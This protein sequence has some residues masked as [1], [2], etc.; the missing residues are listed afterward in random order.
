[1]E[2]SR[3]GSL[4]VRAASRRLLD[5]SEGC[6]PTRKY[7]LKEH[8]V[9]QEL[10]REEAIS[11]GKEMINFHAA[12]AMPI[13]NK[14]LQSGN[15]FYA[16]IDWRLFEAARFE[17]ARTYFRLGHMLQPWDDSWKEQLKQ[18]EDNYEDKLNR[19]PGTDLS[20]R[21]LLDLITKYEQ[22]KKARKK[23]ENCN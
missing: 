2:S 15:E 3:W 6:P 18:L 9:I 12:S 13:I 22:L 19:V 7:L 20:K 4:L 11:L 23:K 10:L 1:M 17:A 16:N 14:W 5:L 8:F 21:Q